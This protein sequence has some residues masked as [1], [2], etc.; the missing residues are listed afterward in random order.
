VSLNPRIAFAGTPA[1][2]VPT[3][4]ALLSSGADISLV[5]TQADRAAGR[6]RKLQ[7]SPVKQFAEANGIP[8]Q[9]PLSLR[10]Q[11]LAASWG[12]RPDLL[13]VAAYG[14]ILPAWV[15]AWPSL[16]A[17]N[18]HASLLPRWRGAAPIQYAIIEG[19][20]ETGVSV[21]RMELGL[22]TGPVYA[23]SPLSIDADETAGDLSDRLAELGA[24]ILIKQLPAIIN[25]TLEPRPQEDS[26]A[27]Y[28]GKISKNDGVLSWHMPAVEIA[29]RIRA[30]NPWPICIASLSD[31][32][33]LRIHQAKLLPN[34]PAANPGTIVA[35]GRDGIDVAAEGG[36]VRLLRVQPPSAKV[37]PVA[38]YLN[39][40]SLDGVSFVG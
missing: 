15:L 23:S 40:H 39:A 35:A 29:R 28:A 10:E 7:A 25:G 22:D 26:T 21:M 31:G 4:R 2:A 14:L 5:L 18:I 27:S 30:F 38:A 6:G 32:R 8:V 19:D 33:T 17:I 34:S 3:L 11:S 13:I 36:I 1:F 12:D 37:M 9:Q 24:D 20:K 16:A